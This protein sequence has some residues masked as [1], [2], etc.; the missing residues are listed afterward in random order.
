[1]LATLAAYAA[2]TDR[3]REA[4][5][6]ALALIALPAGA[7]VAAARTDADPGY[8]L[9]LALL[10]AAGAACWRVSEAPGGAARRARS[11]RTPAPLRLPARPTPGPTAQTR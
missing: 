8:L 6:P 9:A 11:A 7:L 5:L 1:M 3:R 4:R 10:V 2:L